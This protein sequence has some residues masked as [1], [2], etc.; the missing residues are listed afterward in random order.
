MP[1]PWQS[2]VEV[3]Y[4]GNRADEPAGQPADQR[5]AVRR[6]RRG[7]GEPP[8]SAVA[9]GARCGSRPAQSSFDSLQVKFEARDARPLRA[10]QLYVRERASKKSARGARAVTASRTRCNRDFSNLETLL[11]AE[12]GPNAQT[13]R[14]RL[15]FTQ[16]WQLPIGRARAIGAKM[17]RALDAAIGGWQVSSITSIR[18]GCRWR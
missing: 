8:V 6:E 1:L 13:A 4:V 3:A 16:V 2:S 17:S 10:D 9:A 14:H 15:T 18:T 11:R 5:G 12:R 7:A